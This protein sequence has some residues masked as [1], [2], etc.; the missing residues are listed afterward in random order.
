[1]MLGSLLLAIDI[2]AAVYKCVDSDGAITYSQVPCRDDPEEVNV[3]AAG[4]DRGPEPVDCRHANRFAYE[5][6]TNMRNGAS[7]TDV[8]DRY[9]GLGS[10]SKGALNLINYVY[11]FRSD[12]SISPQRIAGLTQTMCEAGTLRD[13]SCDDLP[14]QFTDG[15]GGCEAEEQDTDADQVIAEPAPTTPQFEQAV[16]P[17]QTAVQSSAEDA[18]RR[19]RDSYQDQIERIDEQ[20]RNGYSSAQGESLRDRR[21]NLREQMARC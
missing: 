12:D 19:C 1:M 16:R 4:H 8:F 2:Q 10:V 6:A 3:D 21:R 15:L 20:M 7:S 11:G 18:A 17:G 13:V 14:L 5:T 9:G